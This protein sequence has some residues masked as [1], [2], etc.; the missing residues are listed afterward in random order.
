MLFNK[1][2]NTFDLLRISEEDA[3]LITE[4][5]IL[6]N[7]SKEEVSELTESADVCNDL[8]SLGIVT[9]KTIV[10]LDKTAKISRAY[11]T[12]VFTIARE[13]K[14][15]DFKRLV[16]IWRMERTLEAKLMKKYHAEALKR[17]KASVA[18][19]NSAKK[20]TKSGVVAK[21]VNKAKAQ[22]NSK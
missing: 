9:E 13:K 12:A 19:L 14:D 16:T 3:K 7:L 20:D 22:F 11:K 15:R 2:Y 8:T 1:D 10:R 6:D 5:L 4:S 21:A 18:K 17:A